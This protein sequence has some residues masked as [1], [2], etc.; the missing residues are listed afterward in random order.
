V[1]VLDDAST[2]NSVEVIQQIA[3]QN[4]LVKL[5]RNEKN[6]GVMPNLNK[7]LELARG[8][9]VFIGSADDQVLPGLFEASMKLLAQHPRAGASCTV[10]EWRYEGTDLRWY[11]GV[12]MADRPAYLSPGDLVGVGR[13]G[14]LL[15]SS[16]SVV[17]RRDALNDVGRFVPHLR[18]HADWFA[19]TTCAFRYGLCYV[20]EML[21]LVNILPKSFF[22]AGREGPEHRKVL[23]GI[24]ELLI[25]PAYADVRPLIRD[26]GALSLFAGPMLRLIL[27]RREYRYFLNG[28][29]VGRTLWRSAELIGRKVLPGWLARWVLKTFY[30][31]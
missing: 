2:D 6:L 15:M 29:L 31:K 28:T 24:L 5:V 11:M 17:F 23:E 13:R 16:S 21:S 4:P 22:T 25:S 14:K 30:R 7:G 8:D 9:Y 12:G 20:P 3:A 18:W 27:S 26:S 19:T 10:C 1:I